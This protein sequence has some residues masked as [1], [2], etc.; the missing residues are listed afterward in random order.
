MF[1]FNL[2]HFKNWRMKSEIISYK[3]YSKYPSI[4]RDLSLTL[5]KKIQ[6]STLKQFIQETTKNLININFFDIYFDPIAIDK[7]NLGVRLEFQKNDRTLT[8]LEIDTEISNLLK[9][10]TKEFKIEV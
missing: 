7:V 6:F 10:L 5:N 3:D 4:V 1:E 9:C 8:T 2:V